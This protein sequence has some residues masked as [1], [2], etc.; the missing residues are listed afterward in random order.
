MREWSIRTVSKTVEP[1]GVPGVR[2]PLF[3]VSM[4]R[5]Y[6]WDSNRNERRAGARKSPPDAGGSECRSLKRAGRD[7]CERK[8]NPPLSA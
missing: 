2:I 1:F 6:R 4:H 8:A 5:R 7:A 3:P